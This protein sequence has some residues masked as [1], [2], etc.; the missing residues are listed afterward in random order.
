M[1]R[2]IKQKV[3]KLNTCTCNENNASIGFSCGC[4]HCHDEHNCTESIK[5]KRILREYL[6][7]IVKI[8]TSFT[9]FIITYLFVQ[10]EIVSLILYILSAL[11]VGHQLIIA[12]VK[13]GLK[14][15]FFNEKKSNIKGTYRK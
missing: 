13:D 4:G 6:F 2:D 15:D 11:I 7:D 12:F 10:K 14:G 5:N 9:L 3:D 1:G 8:I